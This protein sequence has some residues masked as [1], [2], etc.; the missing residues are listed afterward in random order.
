MANLVVIG[1]L[2][3]D[4]PVKLDGRPSPGARLQGRSLGGVL[5]GRLGGGGA[6][7]GAALVRAGHHVRL[8]AFAASDA[9]GDLAMALAEAAGLDV[10]QLRRREGASRT[11]ILFID[12]TGERIVLSLDPGEIAPANLP[13]LPAPPADLIAGV[14][15]RAPYPGAQAWA[16][17]ASG[18]VVAHWPCLGFSGPCDVA[19]ASADDCTPEVLADPFAA[20]RA[21]LGDR[22]S[23]FVITHGAGEVVAHD[24]RRQ[25]RVAPRPVQVVDA[26][27]AGDVFA[28]GVL[29][30]LVAG[31][32]MEEALAH[33]CEWGGIAVGLDASAPTEG[34]FRSLA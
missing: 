26:T 24:G 10:S 8:V 12:P 6:N 5:A 23:W 28:A 25:V 32:E 21:A 31:A 7:A 29:D 15:V 18:P 9:D 11:T 14:Y 30:A 20:A 34:D 33:A 2:A 22:L 4:R 16:E 19:V 27:G 1:A 13:A 3:L 17:A